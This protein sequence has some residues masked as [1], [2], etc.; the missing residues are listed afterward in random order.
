M[1]PADTSALIPPLTLRDGDRLVEIGSLDEALVFAETHPLPEGDYGGMIRR[2]Q[3]ARATED[4]IEASNAFKWWA[5]SNA[6][7]VETRLPE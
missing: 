4:R 7:L 3:S 2:L 1:L 5:E 6:I